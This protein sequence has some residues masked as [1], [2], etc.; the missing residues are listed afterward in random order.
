MER[1]FVDHYKYKR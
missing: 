1:Q